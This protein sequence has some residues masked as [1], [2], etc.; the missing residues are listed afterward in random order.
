MVAVWNFG[1]TVTVST[2]FLATLTPADFQTL[3]VLS[4]K[5]IDLFASLRYRESLYCLLG[6]D[7]LAVGRRDSSSPAGQ[8][9]GSVR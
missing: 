5:T 7:V 1:R 2:N 8:T 3:F 9:C 4:A 6:G